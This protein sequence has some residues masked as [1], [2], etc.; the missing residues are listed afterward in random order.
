MVHSLVGVQHLQLVR[1]EAETFRI[2]FEPAFAFLDALIQPIN[3][4]FF[5]LVIL[6]VLHG[7]ETALRVRIVLECKKCDLLEL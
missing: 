6:I 7:V 2:L 4:F 1:S 5:I 3:F